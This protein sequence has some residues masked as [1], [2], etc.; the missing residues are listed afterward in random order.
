M[1]KISVVMLTLETA[2]VDCFLISSLT[3]SVEVAIHVGRSVPQGALY[4]VDAIYFTYAW[5]FLVLQVRPTPTRF[6]TN[7]RST[8]LDNR[9]LKC[10][11]SK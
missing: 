9:P 10:I 2:D 3:F 11:P 8:P 5:V 4:Q 1:R 6:P 7:I